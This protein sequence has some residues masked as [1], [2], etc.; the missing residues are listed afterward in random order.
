M[1][2][3]PRERCDAAVDDREEGSRRRSFAKVIP[4]AR[5]VAAFVDDKHDCVFPSPICQSVPVSVCEGKAHDTQLGISAYDSSVQV[6]G[7]VCTYVRAVEDRRGGSPW[8]PDVPWYSESE[9]HTKAESR[10][11]RLVIVSKS[12]H[13]CELRRRR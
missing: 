1:K 3:D 7:L 13:Y 4:R 9:R 6:T 11:T 8:T 2:T 12:D 10:E 5:L